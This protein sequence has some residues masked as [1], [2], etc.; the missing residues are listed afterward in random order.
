MQWSMGHA[1]SNKCP[2]LHQRNMFKEMKIRNKKLEHGLY[3]EFKETI[4]LYVIAQNLQSI[5]V[6]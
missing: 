6:L 3:T 2:R 5:K 4:T 1:S